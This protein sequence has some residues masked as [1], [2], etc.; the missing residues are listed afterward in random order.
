VRLAHV[1]VLVLRPVAKANSRRAAH[2]FKRILVPLDGSANSAAVLESAA[3]LARCSGARLTLLQVVP[4]VPQ[5]MV[6]VGMPFGTMPSI[7]DDAATEQ[8]V[9]ETKSRLAVR[10][11][12][13]AK[14]VEA[15][16]F[17]VVVE[18]FV[19]QAILDFARGH[20]V[21]AIA[22]ST[23]GR[24]ASRVFFGSIAD[25]VLRASGLPVLFYRP[26]VREPPV[27]AAFQSAALSSV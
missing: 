20:A 6:D 7:P 9:E 21:D 13:L 17:S 26:A 16:D 24:G 14:E 10:A 8:L 23:H 22:M 4:V 2:L 18:T 3:A 5:I 15:V 12:E 1:P 27:S 19:A 11:G 25:K